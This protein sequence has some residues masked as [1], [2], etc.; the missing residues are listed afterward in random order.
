MTKAMEDRRQ[1]MVELKLLT[2]L[3]YH[4]ITNLLFHDAG[5]ESLLAYSD[6]KI[7][8]LCMYN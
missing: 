8:Y 2:P 7:S 4:Y 6:I 1:K 3:K 5:T